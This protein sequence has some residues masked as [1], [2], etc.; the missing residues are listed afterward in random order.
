[1][2]IA[3]PS[4]DDGFSVDPAHLAGVAGQLGQ[5]FDDLSTAIT[6][7]GS[8]SAT[9]ADFGSEVASGWSNFDGAWAQELNI[10]GLALT[11]MIRKVSKTAVGYSTAEV[12]NI[13][14]IHKI[15]G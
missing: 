4:G 5:A 3:V 9:L 15:A 10:L 8:G 1:M 2:P 6:Q 7:Y 12:V 11:E 14:A 13:T